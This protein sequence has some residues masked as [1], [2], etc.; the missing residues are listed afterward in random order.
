MIERSLLVPF[1]ANVMEFVAERVLADKPVKVIVITMKSKGFLWK[2]VINGAVVI[3][4]QRLIRKKVLH[5]TL[6]E[7]LV[8]VDDLNTLFNWILPMLVAIPT[9]VWI[10]NRHL[11]VEVRLNQDLL[12]LEGTEELMAP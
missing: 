12:E 2:Q 6:K 10:T 9:A 8:V 5:L 4:P 11:P 7:G 1:G 3:T